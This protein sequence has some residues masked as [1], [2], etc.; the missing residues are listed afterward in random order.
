MSFEDLRLETRFR[1]IE[2]R[3]SRDVAAIVGTLVAESGGSG[4]PS[5]RASNP[6]FI[7]HARY[8]SWWAVIVEV[9]YYVCKQNV[10][11]NLE[12]IIRY[13]C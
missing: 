3:E 8:V 5:R 9:D 4:G 10:Y 2:R 1:S 12:Q 11:K 7:V 13:L 6:S